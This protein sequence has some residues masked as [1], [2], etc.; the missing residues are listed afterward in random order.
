MLYGPTLSRS[1]QAYSVY[2]D[3]VGSQEYQED[4][5][6][7]ELTSMA[8]KRCLGCNSN[9]GIMATCLNRTPSLFNES[10]SPF[11]LQSQSYGAGSP[12][13]LMSEASPVIAL[14]K[15]ESGVMRTFEDEVEF[16]RAFRNV[17]VEHDCFDCRMLAFISKN[18][19]EAA[20]NKSLDERIKSLIEAALFY[21]L[22][23]GACRLSL[24]H[25]LLFQIGI[26]YTKIPNASLEAQECLNASIEEMKASK[27][28]RS[29]T[30]MCDLARYYC[31]QEKEGLAVPLI[32]ELLGDAY[33]GALWMW[34]HAGSVDGFC[35]RCRWQIAPK[36]TGTKCLDCC[37]NCIEDA[38]PEV[39]GCHFCL[40]CGNCIKK[41]INCNRLW[42]AQLIEPWNTFYAFL[43]LGLSK[44]Y[45]V[46]DMDDPNDDNR[47]LDDKGEYA[48]W[49]IP[50]AKAH[51][52]HSAR[53]TTIF[54]PQ[55]YLLHGWALGRRIN[56]CSLWI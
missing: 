41:G 45:A 47:E 33:R 6:D 16:Q 36:L 44:R 32:R 20:N 22:K 29:R 17:S 48:E 9:P 30:A 46:V 14:L 37:R 50:C 38:A 51:H 11:F 10:W 15:R 25:N 18:T 39:L 53:C 7:S 49:D 24:L 2:S 12:S 52:D 4:C 5:A 40:R 19:R 13:L 31:T 1:K 23:P 56:H 54:R 34:R 42:L 26:F 27:D 8:S 28:I 55:D 35:C 21:A 3:L 43:L